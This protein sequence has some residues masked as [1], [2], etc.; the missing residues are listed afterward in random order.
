MTEPSETLIPPGYL[1]G[2]DPS[3]WSRLTWEILIHAAERP[4]LIGV[5]V[6]G[7]RCE[8]CG[9]DLSGAL[10]IDRESGAISDTWNFMVFGSA[11]RCDGCLRE[12][13]WILFALSL[14]GDSS[15][16]PQVSRRLSQHDGDFPESEWQGPLDEE[17]GRGFAAFLAPG[18]VCEFCG[19]PVAGI[20]SFDP[21]TLR[22]STTLGFSFLGGR[23]ACQ[24]CT[25]GSA[26]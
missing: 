23:I 7:I 12:N 3:S 16:T 4:D 5:Y 17:R 8:A 20:L 13:S 15:W 19:K 24:E 26:R 6:T 9:R 2:V 22:I 1:P 18:L 14:L 10:F 11:V 25:E 21:K